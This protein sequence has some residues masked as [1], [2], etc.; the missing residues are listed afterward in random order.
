MVILSVVFVVGASLGIALQMGLTRPEAEAIKEPV[1]IETPPVASR[2]I[3]VK[4]ET[5][6][7]TLDELQTTLEKMVASRRGTWSVYV[8]DL[9]TAQSISINNGTMPAA[10]LIKIFVMAT[11]FDQIER[12]ELEDSET[13]R[14][15]L[16]RMITISENEAWYQLVPILGNGWYGPGARKI[17]EYALANGYLD[18]IHYGDYSHPQYTLALDVSQTSVRDCGLLLE[19]IY[20]GECVSKEASASMLELL[21]KQTLL[22]K[23]PAGLPKGVKSANKT[24]ELSGIQNDVALVFAPGGTYVIC[25]MS[26]DVSDYAS[27]QTFI[28]ELSHVVYLYLEDV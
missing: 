20:N 11:V 18:T 19:R 8:K 15:L 27:E 9:D 7:V 14:N 10:S 12:G 26:E 13:I 24:G 4:P 22:S 17:N 28:A 23:I 1:R 25:V 3:A 5:P 21:Q 2:S 6:V 16:T